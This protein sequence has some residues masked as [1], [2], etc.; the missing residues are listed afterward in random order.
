MIFLNSLIAVLA[1]FG[2]RLCVLISVWMVN[3]KLGA[4]TLGLYTMM[5]VADYLIKREYNQKMQ[6]LIDQSEKL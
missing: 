3:S 2:V 6:Q 5:N 4:I 1:D